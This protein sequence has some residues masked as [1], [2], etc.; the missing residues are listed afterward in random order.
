[1]VDHDGTGEDVRVCVL[2]DRE[3][4]LGPVQQVGAGC[5]SPTHVAPRVSVG[6]VL[7]EQV[8]H[9]LVE[10]QAVGIVH[11]I[12]GGEEVGASNKFEPGDADRGQPTF[13]DT[14]R[15]K[16]VFG[17]TVPANFGET[18][19]L[20]WSVTVRGKTESVAGMLTSV[21]QIDRRRTT[22]GGNSQNINSNTPPTVTATPATQS[23]AR[24][25]TATLRVSATDDGLP[26]RR[27]EGGVAAPLGM[28]VEWAKYRGPGAVTWNRQKQP[29]VDGK[30]DVSATFSEPGEYLLLAVV[31][32]GSGESVQPTITASPSPSPSKEPSEEPSTATPST[33]PPKTQTPSQEPTTEEPS[34]EPTTQEPSEEPSTGAPTTGEPENPLDPRL[35]Q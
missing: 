8:I 10:H 11:P 2:R 12:L 19:K 23:V 13:F 34:E 27:G 6:V 7:I 28:T 26:R 14:R 4:L 30:A 21:W 20:T 33:K 15:H 17:V 22:R 31:D 5:V 3:R 32:D 9:P 24:A 35:S 29:L 18:A 1:M 16:D 25:A